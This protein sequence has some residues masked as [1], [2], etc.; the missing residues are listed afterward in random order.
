M[1]ILSTEPKRTIE[2]IRMLDSGQ[3][4][5][6]DGP[7]TKARLLENNSKLRKAI[8]Y[9]VGRVDRIEPVED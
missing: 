3:L 5:T 2:V 8:E 1:A 7:L 6:S 4:S 9:L